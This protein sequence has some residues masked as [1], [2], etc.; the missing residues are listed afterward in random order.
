VHLQADVHAAANARVLGDKQLDALQNI[1][2]TLGDFLV[3]QSAA[4]GAFTKAIVGQ[5]TYGAGTVG[6][7]ERSTFDASNVARTSVET[8][9]SNTAFLPVINL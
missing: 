9:G 8:R 1:N 2:G 5:S 4:S 3:S 6:D 7:Y